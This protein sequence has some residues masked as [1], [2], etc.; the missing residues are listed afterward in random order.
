MQKGKPNDAG[1]KPNVENRKREAAGGTYAEKRLPELERQRQARIKRL[2]EL[3]RQQI[4]LHNRR[5]ENGVLGRRNNSKSY[6]KPTIVMALLTAILLL[7][8]AVNYVEK[9]SDLH[10]SNKALASLKKEY[11]QL[12]MDN[13]NREALLNASV[14][15]QQIYWIAT[16]QLGMNYPEKHQVITYHKTESG[17]V[18]QYE[19]IPQ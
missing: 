1:G 4:D 10:Q 17:Y 6:D 7:W 5:I 3:E 12:Q 11:E 2:Q 15:V 8:S 13:D 9:N 19:D 14:D 18:A 16:Q